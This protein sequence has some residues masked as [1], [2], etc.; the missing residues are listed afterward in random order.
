[1]FFTFQ[2]FPG[3]YVPVRI[4]TFPS[5]GNEEGE[6]TVGIRDAN[7]L[8]LYDL[9]L[10]IDSVRYVTAATAGTYNKS[11]TTLVVTLVNH[12]LRV[13]ESAFLDYTSGTAVD[14]TL[15]ITSTTDDTFT[16]TS[17]AS[18]TTAGTVNVRQEFS[19]TADG[20]ADT[21]WT[22]QRVK[23]RSMP[24]PVTLLAGERLVDRVVE[25]D[26]GVNSTYSQSGN[27]VTCLLYT[28]PS[29]RD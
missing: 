18:V 13:G 28:S 8:N 2:Y 29:P 4:F 14:E 12:G 27:T 21:R 20:F 9:G 25:R 1:M 26:S 10:P 7:S 16:C 11:G 22:D 24:T 5:A 23:I 6:H 17:S 3:L 19:D 15:V